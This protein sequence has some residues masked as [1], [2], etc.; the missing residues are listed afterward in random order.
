METLEKTKGTYIT[1]HGTAV[2]IRLT[3]RVSTFG[4]G[5]CD[6]ALPVSKA[7]R[8][9][10][11]TLAIAIGVSHD[12]GVNGLVVGEI[13]LDFLAGGDEMYDVGRRELISDHDHELVLREDLNERRD[14]GLWLW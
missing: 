6:I 5:L 13:H 4:R 8:S 10:F 14:G 3:V 12:V 2:I 9:G 11:D 1:D 7:L